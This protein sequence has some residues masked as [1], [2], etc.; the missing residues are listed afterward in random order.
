MTLKNDLVVVIGSTFDLVEPSP[1]SEAPKLDHVAR[2][3]DFCTW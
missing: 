3:V 1:L 2:S